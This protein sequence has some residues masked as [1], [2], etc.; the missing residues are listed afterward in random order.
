[1]DFGVVVFV[2]VR[3]IH[4]VG[5]V[6]W[7]SIAVFV[8][9]IARPAMNAAG[10]EAGKPTNWLFGKGQIRTVISAASGLT[11]LSGIYLYL[12]NSNLFRNG[13]WLANPAGIIFGI[14]A[15]LGMTGGAIGGR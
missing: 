4:I 9:F 15:V 6:L 1:M 2:V 7:V 8:T 12:N 10:A 13:D 14:G 11:I 5:A 3:L